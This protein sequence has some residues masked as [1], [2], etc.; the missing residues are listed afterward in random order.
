M[1]TQK[2]EMSEAAKELLKRAKKLNL[3]NFGMLLS[4]MEKEFKKR[5]RG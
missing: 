4:E 5:K 3:I 1:G 2:I